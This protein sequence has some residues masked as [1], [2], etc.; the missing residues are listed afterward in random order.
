M[1]SAEPSPE[2]D[3]YRRYT[4]MKKLTAVAVAGLLAGSLVTTN[5]TAAKPKQQKVS[6]SIAL[7]APFTDDSGCF[8]GLHRRMAILT[9]EQVNGIVG[10]HFDLEP[11][12]LGKPFVLEVTGGQGNV[13][14]DI[15]FYYEF[16]TPEDVVN[17][18]QGAG[19]PVSYGY[20]TREVGGESGT[21]PKGDY[22]KA[23]VCVYGGQQ[24]AGAA[25]S[26]EYTAG[27]GVKLP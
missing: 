8:A 1:T 5:A 15:L 13:D 20:Q 16:G 2:T 6:G 10:Y 4:I 23:I 22:T 25:A 19:A 21:V 17:D 26:F 9:Q 14:M 11:A 12:T 27:K 24:G 3:F 18:P 7:P